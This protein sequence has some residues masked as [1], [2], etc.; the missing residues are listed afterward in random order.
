VFDAIVIGAG[1]HGLA[2][3][4]YLARAGWAVTVLE[5]RSLVGGCSATE[6][7]LGARVNLCN[8]DHIMVRVNPLLEELDLAAQ[9]LDYLEAD[10]NLCGIGWEGEPPVLVF[11][12][13]DRTLEAWRFTHGREGERYRSYLETALPA[14]RLLTAIT[15]AEPRT[16]TILSLIRS[17]GGKAARTL[18]SWRSRSLLEVMGSH[19][20]D[21]R[22]IRPL[23]AFTTGVWGLPPSAP[24]TGYGALAYA[25][26]HVAGAGRPRGGSGALG[27]A[28]RSVLESRSGSV[29]C[30]A[31]VTSIQPLGDEIA[32][33]LADGTQLQAPVVVSAICPRRTLLELVDHPR[34]SR[35]KRS[36][37]ATAA[38]DGYQSKIDAV[39]DQLPQMEA[40]TP[41]LAARL[42]M[43]SP[44]VPSIAITP[45]IERI[46]EMPD[47]H[48]RGVIPDPPLMVLNIPSVLDPSMKSGDHH[49]M[50]LEVLF[51]PYQLQGGWHDGVPT[52]WIGTFSTIAGGGFPSAIRAWRAMTPPL[53]ERDLH[54]T[55][56]NPPAFGGSPLDVL[57]GRKRHLTR[58]T[59]P[60][61]GFYLTGAGTYPGGGIW[62][63]AGRNAAL[64]ILA[65]SR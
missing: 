17:A 29:R 48:R 26:R 32:V 46:E 45:S 2:C 14:A 4:A 25:L 55:R 3:A 51:T 39:I 42:E 8:C 19:F 37:A 41:G 65:D 47:L 61:R 50:S 49:I 54:L 34:L 53:Y 7:A 6:E 38:V 44:F 35:L 20:D 23:A 30:N 36:L 60:W 40:F 13:P 33:S 27:E 63:A 43:G 16:A 5:A 31:R 52:T 10:P 64:R 22:L 21:E 18:L 24:N 11:K 1:H 28:L 57:L 15:N 59:T 62:G 9:G 56:G 12:D 58:Y